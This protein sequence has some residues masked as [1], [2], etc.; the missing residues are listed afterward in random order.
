MEAPVKFT[1]LLV[2][3]IAILSF[4]VNAQSSGTGDGPGNNGIPR[5]IENKVDL[6]VKNQIGNHEGYNN[7]TAKDCGVE[8]VAP[9]YGTDEYGLTV[10]STFG[11]WMLSSNDFKILKKSGLTQLS[12]KSTSGGGLGSYWGGGS[13]TRV[14][15]DVLIRFNK[16]GYMV[17]VIITLGDKTVYCEF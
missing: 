10:Y 2:L 6:I 14:A 11:A 4:S 1:N 8:V 15:Q 17:E 5:L 7:Q 12:Y 13:S 16:L 9:Q 3:S